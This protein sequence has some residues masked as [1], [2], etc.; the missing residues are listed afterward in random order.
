[1]AAPQRGALNWRAIADVFLASRSDR[2]ATTRRDLISRVE[3]ALTTLA[4]HPK[5]KSGPELM[6]RYAADHFASCPPGGQG[7]K[8]QLA[9][10]STL[11]EARLLLSGLPNSCVQYVP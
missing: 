9:A 6:R 4:S 7:R 1:M 5:P 11:L 2:R 10:T 8:R 3:R